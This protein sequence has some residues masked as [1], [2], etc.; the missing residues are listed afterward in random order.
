MKKVLLIGE[1]MAMFVADELGSLDK[2]EKYT[3]M[4]AGAEVNVGIGLQRLE[5]PCTYVTRLGDEP[6]GRAIYTRLQNEGIDTSF[7]TFDTEF[8]T[9]IQLKSKVEKGDPEVVYYRKNSAAS[10]MTP[11]HIANID[12]SGIRHIHATGIPPALSDSC[13]EAVVLLLQKAKEQGISTSFD[14]N[15]RPAL[16]PNQQTMIEVINKLAAMCDVVLPG[17]SEGQL[18]TGKEAIEDV[19]QFYLDAGS[20]AVVIKDGPKGAFVATKQEKYRVPG[21]TVEKV[22]DTVGAGDGFAVGVISGRLDGL[23]LREAVLRGNAIGAIQVTSKGDNEG[24]PTRQE[25]AAFMQK[26]P[27]I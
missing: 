27:A 6:L 4:L 21:F 15:L 22:M 11:E 2:V 7:V 1:P 23:P 5:L 14:P 24:L 8:F 26:G 17:H 9:G 3:K 13:R 25:L 16:W 20:S 12:F 19:A 18:L 10:H